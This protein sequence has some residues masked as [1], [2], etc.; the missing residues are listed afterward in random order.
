MARTIDMDPTDDAS[1]TGYAKTILDFGDGFALDLRKPLNEV[2][3]QR[4][5]TL[6]VAMPFA[7]ISAANAKGEEAADAINEASF[8]ALR[9][10][11]NTLGFPYHSVWGRSADG[12]HEERGLAVHATMWEARELAIAAEQSAFFWCDGSSFWIVG[13]LVETPAICLPQK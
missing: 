10:A 9:N 8:F 13:A 7:V 4:L 1:W 12:L 6:P 2:S 3:R 5:A 11:V